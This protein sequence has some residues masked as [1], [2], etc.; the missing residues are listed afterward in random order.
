MKRVGINIDS[1]VALR[2]FGGGKVPDPIH[3][4]AMLEAAGVDSIVYTLPGTPSTSVDRDLPLLKESVHSHFNLR[5]AV[6]EAAV[7]KATA[8]GAEMVTLI[9]W[10]GHRSTSIDLVRDESV[11]RGTVQ[12]LR[13]AGIVVNALVEPDANQL[14]AAVQTGCDYVELHA[15][16]FVHAESIP[17]MEQ[18]LDN[19]K[20]MALAAAKLKLGVTLSGDLDYT[21]LRSVLGIEELEEINV[22]HAVISRAL[23]FG[24]D[25]AVRD[26]VALV[27]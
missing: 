10:E 24:V 23:F 4:I 12:G 20:V 18:E 11:V 27:H 17:M 15:H 7:R 14:K 8:A 19:L 5:L 1:V 3:V 2:E 6:S 13:Q 21:N 16:R 26:L 9:G 25:R 22:G